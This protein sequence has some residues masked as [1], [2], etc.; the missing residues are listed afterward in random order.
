MMASNRRYSIPDPDALYARSGELL[1]E[2]L[3]HRITN[4]YAAAMAI[5]TLMIRQTIHTD[6]KL[7][8]LD[9]R[10]CLENFARVHH[11]L[12]RPGLPTVD[13]LAYL[14]ELC[15]AIELSRLEQRDI[16]LGLVGQTIQMDCERC[17]RLGMIVSELIANS[18]QA[19]GEGEGEIRI[20]LYD[21]E[22]SSIAECR[23]QYPARPS[24][25]SRDVGSGS[26][27]L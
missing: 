2:E 18:A 14:Q 4:E 23:T 5:V 22:A 24:R 13:A 19:Y 21:Q 17:W 12:Q 6:V 1:L 15:Q 11:A 25:F 8:L 26:C 7:A 16:K 10:T 3:T 9:V 20:E 27:A